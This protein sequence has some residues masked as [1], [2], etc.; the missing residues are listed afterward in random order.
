MTSTIYDE[1]AHTHVTVYVPQEGRT[2]EY[3]NDAWRHPTQIVHH[4][5]KRVW[6][7]GSYSETDMHPLITMVHDGSGDPYD[8]HGNCIL[9]V[10]RE[11]CRYHDDKDAESIARCIAID[12]D[13]LAYAKG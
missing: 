8:I 9:S 10:P 5:G 2:E 1:R 12:D 11:W 13:L 3:H 6:I 7:N 4:T